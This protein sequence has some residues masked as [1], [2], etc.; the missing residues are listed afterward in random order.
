GHPIRGNFCF[1]ATICVLRSP[2]L[3]VHLTGVPL[4][5][6]PAGDFIVSL[7]SPAI[8][9]I[10]NMNYKLPAA[11]IIES[12]NVEGNIRT[13]LRLDRMQSSPVAPAGIFSQ[14]EPRK[15][16]LELHYLVERRQDVL[17]FITYNTQDS[18]LIP[19]NKYDFI[20][21]WTPNQLALAQDDSHE[22]HKRTFTPKDMITF[23]LED[24]GVIARA[25]EEGDDTTQN[26]IVKDSWDHEHCELCWETISSYE[27]YQ[28]VAYTDGKNWLCQNCYE[29][30]ILSGFGKK[31]GEAS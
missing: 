20:S 22:W 28:N 11:E 13:A 7:Q 27:G 17:V 12:I 23:K 5:S 6:T 2:N 31:L 9:G 29:R 18:P 19:G 10:Q 26:N 25:I 14:T 24:G 4:R 3:S 30:Y 8:V 1:T 21:Q 16:L 15:R